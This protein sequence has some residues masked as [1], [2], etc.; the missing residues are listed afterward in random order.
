MFTKAKAEFEIS[1]ILLGKAQEAH[2][3][4]FEN[5]V[6]PVDPVDPDDES[7]DDEATDDLDEFEED[8]E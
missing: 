1:E 3:D 5:T 6:E 8:F 2:P 7:M 4:A